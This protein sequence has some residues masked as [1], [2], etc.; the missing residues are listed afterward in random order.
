MHTSTTDR[1]ELRHIDTPE[2]WKDLC[3][4]KQRENIALQAENF[5]LKE[6]LR[7]ESD[8]CSDVEAQQ[9]RSSRKRPVVFNEIEDLPNDNESSDDVDLLG[10][11]FFRLNGHSNVHP[12]TCLP[13]YL[14]KDS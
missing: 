2:F 13:I 9:C 8:V 4:K 11:P 10:D 5:L 12:P 7:S 1:E 6:R 14:T 3:D